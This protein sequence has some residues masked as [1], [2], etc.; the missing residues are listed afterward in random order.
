MID[1]DRPICAGERELSGRNG[2]QHSRRTAGITKTSLIVGAAI[3]FAAAV[4]GCNAVPPAVPADSAPISAME[5]TAASTPDAAE[6]PATATPDGENVIDSTSG[7][8]EPPPGQDSE[9]RSNGEAGSN[10]DDRRPTA[11]P[12]PQIGEITFA[13]DAADNYEPIAPGILFTKGITEVHALFEY[14]GMW[15]DSTWERVWYVNEGEV[16][17]RSGLWTGPEQGV[18]DYFVDNGGK[19]LPAGDW[20]LEIYVDGKLRTLGAFIIDD[21]AAAIDDTNPP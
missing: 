21:E 4:L 7:G 13:L 14:S 16:S 18:F 1:L 8:Q 19:P 12:D 5:S 2:L 9:T 10:E 17:R 20:L 6:V 11:R 3:L 15:P